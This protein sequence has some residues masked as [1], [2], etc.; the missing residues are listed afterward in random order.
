MKSSFYGGY[1][2][3]KSINKL[4]AELYFMRNIFWAFLNV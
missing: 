2:D 1:S 3:V 4:P